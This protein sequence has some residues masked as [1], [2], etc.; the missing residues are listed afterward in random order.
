MWKN[1]IKIRDI[2]EDENFDE[3][4]SNITVYGNKMCERLLSYP[5]LATADFPSEFKKVRT[6][7]EFNNVLNNFYD[8]CDD[9]RIWVEF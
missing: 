1:R 9:N 8:Y 3:S 6:L 7:D 4:T 2:S 5:F